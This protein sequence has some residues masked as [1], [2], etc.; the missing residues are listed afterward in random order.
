M[1]NKCFQY[2]NKLRQNVEYVSSIFYGDF[3]TPNL[4]NY[5]TV[6]TIAFTAL[7]Q[8]KLLN[9]FQ[10]INVNDLVNEQVAKQ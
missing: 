3:T 5:R 7:K 9:Y 1:S 8:S 2:P 10:C 4:G 6:M